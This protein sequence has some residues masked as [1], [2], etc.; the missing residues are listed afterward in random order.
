MLIGGRE[1]PP[2]GRPALIGVVNLSPESHN[3]DSVVPDAAGAV[4]RAWELISAGADVIDVGGRSTHFAAPDIPW[5][6]ERERVLPAVAALKEHGFLV[7]ID[8]WDSRV[9]Q[10]ALAEGADLV[11]AS[12]GLQ[13]QAMMAA[14]GE[15]GRPAVAPYLRGPT[16]RTSPSPGGDDP[17]AAMLAWF[18]RALARWDDAGL[19]EVVLDPGV[20]YAHRDVSQP[21]RDELQ[22]RVFAELGRL[23]ALGRP[24]LAPV[25]RKPRREFTLELIELTL[26]AGVAFLRTHEPA[27]AYEALARH[28]AT[29]SS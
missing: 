12:D 19:R 8:S 25:M 4:R 18:E 15:A 7:S 2:P 3:A 20:G 13:S 29:V 23:A 16:P 17:L 5:R 24:I 1:F 22:R 21:V 28:E 26:D 27:L 10:A 14:V 9:V 6:I 11:N